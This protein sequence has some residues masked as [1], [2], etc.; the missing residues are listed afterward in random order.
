[1]AGQAHFRSPSTRATSYQCGGVPV[2]VLWVIAALVVGGLMALRLYRSGASNVGYILGMSI[3][4]VIAMAVVAP[5]LLSGNR[6]DPG[7]WSQEVKDLRSS[8]P[9]SRQPDSGNSD[10]S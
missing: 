7:D 1:M 9:A 2:V 3:A 10:E 6:R 8:T 5:N 4:A